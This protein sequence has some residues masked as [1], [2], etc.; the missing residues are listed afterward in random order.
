MIIRRWAT[1]SRWLL[2]RQK[3]DVKIVK[4]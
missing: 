3:L 1:M 2:V 4:F